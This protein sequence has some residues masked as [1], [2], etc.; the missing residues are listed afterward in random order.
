MSACKLCAGVR[1]VASPLS[2]QPSRCPCANGHTIALLMLEP[3]QQLLG[4]CMCCTRGSNAPGAFVVTRR[5][6]LPDG[7]FRDGWG[8]PEEIGALSTRAAAFCGQCAAF[9][10]GGMVTFGEV[11]KRNGGRVP[12]G[13]PFVRSC[14]LL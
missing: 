9:V 1:F 10:G 2:G 3:V 14:G 5:S 12:A 4:A 7:S 11:A 13:A 6:W 8:A